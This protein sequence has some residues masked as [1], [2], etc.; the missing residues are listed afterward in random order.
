MN[1]FII[2]YITVQLKCVDVLL[3]FFR[4]NEILLLA[5]VCMSLLLQY[6]VVPAFGSTFPFL[7][8]KYGQTR[9]RTSLVHSMMVGLTMGLGNW[10]YILISFV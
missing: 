10:R 8:E 1:D 5:A 3:F 4:V 9:A 2:V 7:L 6:G